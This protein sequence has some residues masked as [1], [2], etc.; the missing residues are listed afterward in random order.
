MFHTRQRRR[1][2]TG[3]WIA[4]VVVLI[5]GMAWLTGSLRTETRELVAFFDEAR[6]LTDDA[7]QQAD[8][9]REL[10]RAQLTNLDRDQFEVLVE[11]IESSIGEGAA[12]LEAL[13]VPDSAAPS[14]EML[15]LAFASWASGL[16]GV[17]RSVLGIADDPSS[18]GAVDSLNSAL[19]EL[20][21][22]D[23]LYSRF[24]DRAVVLTA[25]LDV[26]IGDFGD[27]SFVAEEPVLRNAELIASAV[28]GSSLLEARRDMAILQPVFV[29]TNTGG[30]TPGGADIF[31]A[32]EQLAYAVV[33][34]NNGNQV[35]KG[36]VVEARF[37]DSQGLLL[38][39]QTSET[40]DLE[41]DQKATVSFAP[42]QVSPGQTYELVLSTPIVEDDLDEANNTFIREIAI[43]ARG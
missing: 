14:A 20:Q 6:I 24:L 12:Q 13:T 17:Q 29:P 11:N 41:P 9:Y 18:T 3:W 33:I 15:S 34:G 43:Q 26:A 35:E 42:V 10:L 38:D 5:V 32:T 27:V 37:F 4:G 19:V 31:P 7:A 22:G 28:R 25:D 23:L 1:R 30:R 39:S 36:V 16:D 8:A 2:R 40:V 21:V